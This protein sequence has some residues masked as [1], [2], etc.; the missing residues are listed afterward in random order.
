MNGGNQGNYFESI[1]GTTAGETMTSGGGAIDFFSGFGGNDTMSV[2]NGTRGWFRG[3]DGDDIMTGADQDDQ[4][5]GGEG[6]DTFTGN[7]GID[8]DEVRY[9][10][11]A[12][13]APP[14][15]LSGVFVN[16]SGAD[17]TMTFNGQSTTVNANRARD[18]WGDTDILFGIEDV[19][20]SDEADIIVGNNGGN[21][22]E[23]AEGRRHSDGPRRDDVYVYSWE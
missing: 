8:G 7:G 3:G 16:L 15:P 10:R 22:I 6:A 21:R 20:G 2:G 12:G 14:D 11:F 13:S 5:I 23:G 4:F 9:D 18:N 1:L 17:V 19:R